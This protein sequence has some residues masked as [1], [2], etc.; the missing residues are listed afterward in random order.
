MYADARRGTGKDP[1]RSSQHYTAVADLRPYGY[2]AILHLHNKHGKAADHKLEL[3][4]TGG[5]GFARL[6][7]QIEEIFEVDAMRLDLMRLDLA[8][9]VEGVPVTFFLDS[10]RAAYKRVAKDIEKANRIMRIGRRGVETITLGARPNLFRI[11]DKAA[12]RA[13][14]YDVRARNAK[15]LGRSIPTYEEL[16]GHPREN[17]LLTRVER[18]YGGGRIP[19][20]I[21]TVGALYENSLGVSPFEPLAICLSGRPD[22]NP[23]DYD[24]MNFLAGKG[25]RQQILEQGLQRTRGLVN[26]KSRGNAAR[27]FRKLGDFLP[28]SPEGIKVPD[29]AGLFQQSMQR[30]FQA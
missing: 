29:L 2:D 24:L 6:I 18:Q 25:L 9:D 21:S 12:E 5:K 14:R 1:F 22:P 11:Y 4:E 15:K 3:L 26:K 19:E 17:Y 16:Y 23:D 20:E 27:V 8:V 10:V 7:Y 28:V 13:H 30:Q